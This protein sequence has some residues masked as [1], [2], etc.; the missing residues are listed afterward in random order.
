MSRKAVKSLT[1]LL[2]PGDTSGSFGT[3]AATSQL[4]KSCRA[5]DFGLVRPTPCGGSLGT[6]FLYSRK[7]A[8]HC[9]NWCILISFISRRWLQKP[10]APFQKAVDASWKSVLHL[11]EVDVRF[12]GFRG[13]SSLRT[14]TWPSGISVKCTSAYEQYR[15]LQY[16]HPTH[17]T[18]TSRLLYAA[19]MEHTST[20]M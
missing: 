7:L 1:V 10:S 13:V 16:L 14:C 8:A 15:E 19:L 4:R 17:N 6:R 12:G 20:A 2:F 11:D 18:G 9:I 5:S 3:T